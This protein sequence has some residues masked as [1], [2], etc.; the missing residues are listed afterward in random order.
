[1][2]ILNEKKSKFLEETANKIR[3]DIVEM[4]T[5]AG[6]GIRLRLWAPPTFCRSVFSYFKS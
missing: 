5:E 2:E 4:L 3:Q 1:M 6:S